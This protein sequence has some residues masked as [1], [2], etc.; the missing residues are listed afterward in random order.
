MVLGAGNVGTHLCRALELNPGV[1]LLQNYNRKGMKIQDCH[2]P[3]IA[4]LSD[5]VPAEVYIVTYSD[6]ALSEEKRT[7]KDLEGFTPKYKML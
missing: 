1:L 7:L 4:K 5:I 2:V 3:V 6:N